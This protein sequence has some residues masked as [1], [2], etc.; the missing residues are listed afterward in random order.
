MKTKLTGAKFKSALG[1]VGQLFS[2]VACLG[3][4][5]FVCS[6]VSAQNLFVSG[7]GCSGEILKDPP[8]CG[9]I[10]RFTSGGQQSIFVSGMNYPGDLAFDGAG[11][12]FAVECEPC[13]TPHPSHAIYKINPVGGRTRFASGLTYSPFLAADQAG[14]LFVADYD[15][16]I[17]Y[18]YKPSGLEGI[19]ASGLYHPTGMAFDSAGNLFVADNSVGNFYHGSIYKYTPDGSRVIFAILDPSDRP[20]DLA[21]NSIGNLFMADLG[22]NIYKYDLHGVRT[23]FGSVPNGAQSL[24]CDSADNLFVLDASDATIYKFTPQG[25]RSIFASGQA[26]GETFSHVAFH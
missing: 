16:G 3:V 10:F 17:I 12:L 4:V 7:Y 11:N 8:A 15:D 26:L 24:A 14:N 18:Q 22:G 23:T 2:R 6:S 5:I 1:L 25:A 19:F 20:G 13:W 21:F 9:R